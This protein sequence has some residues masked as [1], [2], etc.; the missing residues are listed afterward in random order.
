MEFDL[1]NIGGINI[2]LK[3]IEDNVSLIAKDIPV[4]VHC[5]SGA[6]SASAISKLQLHGF[7]NLL[8]LKGGIL[9]WIEEIN[10]SLTK[11]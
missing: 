3:N 6:R 2:P 10:P 1:V 9:S 11:Y 5:K 4:V 8:N 7:S